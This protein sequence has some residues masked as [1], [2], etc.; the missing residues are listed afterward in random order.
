MISAIDQ[1]T[2]TRGERVLRNGV[3]V[4]VVVMGN[5]NFGPKKIGRGLGVL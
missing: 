3:V 2:I 4:S 5:W 1:H